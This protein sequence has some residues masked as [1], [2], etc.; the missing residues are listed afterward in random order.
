MMKLDEFTEGS[1]FLY[2][3]QYIEELLGI[4]K[5]IAVVHGPIETVQIQWIWSPYRNGYMREW[6]YDHYNMVD[7]ISNCQPITEQEKLQ[8]LLKYEFK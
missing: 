4:G 3:N 8:L 7:W 2:V 1:L 6:S 5:V